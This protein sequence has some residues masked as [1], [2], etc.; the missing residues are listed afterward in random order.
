MENNKYFYRSICYGLF[1][2]GCMVNFPLMVSI[3]ISGIVTML[4]ITPSVDLSDDYVR[5]LRTP[6]NQ[7]W[8]D[9]ETGWKIGAIIM[10][11]IVMTAV[12]Y[13]PVILLLGI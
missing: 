13:R 3:T 6:I 7:D 5:M 9:E 4:F 1:I 12:L 10:M 8:N 11:F 2:F